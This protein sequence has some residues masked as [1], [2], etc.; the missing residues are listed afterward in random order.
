MF[1]GKEI[2]VTEVK[3][4]EMED[5]IKELTHDIN[6]LQKKE[7]RKDV[8]LLEY[9]QMHENLKQEI[10]DSKTSKENFI[11]KILLLFINLK[12]A[13]S[14]VFLFYPFFFFFFFFLRFM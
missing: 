4:K 6:L 13:C 7:L 11:Q 2:S 9:T 14:S 12:K 3:T 1:Q 5:M 8:S 10:A